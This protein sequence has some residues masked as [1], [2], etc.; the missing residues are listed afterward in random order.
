MYTPPTIDLPP[1]PWDHLA[2]PAAY[3]PAG[4]KGSKALR[5]QED[6]HTYLKV[7]ITPALCPRD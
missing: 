6:V 7:Y 2:T 3:D 1:E 5:Q 4:T